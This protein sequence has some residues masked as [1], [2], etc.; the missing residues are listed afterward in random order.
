[1]EQ[2]LKKTTTPHMYLK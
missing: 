2:G 1:M